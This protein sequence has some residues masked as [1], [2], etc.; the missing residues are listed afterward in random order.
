MEVSLR[1]ALKD[2]QDLFLGSKEELAT[3][4][5]FYA[6]I[7][8]KSRCLLSVTYLYLFPLFLCV[9]LC[10]CNALYFSLLRAALAPLL[11]MNSPTFTLAVLA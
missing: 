11:T 8:S 10:L 1:K 6:T 9:C 3:C 4:Y 5:S 7:L 2:I